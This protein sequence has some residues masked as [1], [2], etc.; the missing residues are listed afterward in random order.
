M[1][2][3]QINTEEPINENRGQL[4]VRSPRHK[5]SRNDKCPIKTPKTQN[6]GAPPL[7]LRAHEKRADLVPELFN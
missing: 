1:Q 5:K 4:K 2:A 3:S 7:R 6:S